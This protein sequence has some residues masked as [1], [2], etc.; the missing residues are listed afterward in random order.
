[1][2]PGERPK[3]GRRVRWM[4]RKRCRKVY[5]NVLSLQRC[6][7]STL[8][9]RFHSVFKKYIFY[10]YFF[11]G[12]RCAVGFGTTTRK[13]LQTRVTGFWAPGRYG[14][15]FER[16]KK[17]MFFTCVYR[18]KGL[19]AFLCTCPWRSRRETLWLPSMSRPSHRR[20]IF[21]RDGYRGTVSYCDYLIICYHS[22]RLLDRL[23][24]LI[25]QPLRKY[26]RVL[27]RRSRNSKD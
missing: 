12:G 16:S 19:L 15:R 25:I 2:V 18:K 13:I 4:S 8:L 14:R 1:M 23:P 9:L 20:W 21:L 24:M 11:Q 7:L 17:E 10:F 5:L 22:N 6:I 26:L 3:V 27:S